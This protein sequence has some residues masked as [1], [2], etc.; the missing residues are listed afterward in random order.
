M[1]KSDSWLRFKVEYISNKTGKRCTT[2]ITANN[3]LEA[4]CI[5][6]VLGKVLKVVPL[7]SNTRKNMS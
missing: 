5:V 1:S 2:E 4:S 7:P 6:G 3:K